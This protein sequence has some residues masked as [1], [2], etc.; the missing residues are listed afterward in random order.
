MR[1]DVTHVQYFIIAWNLPRHILRIKVDFA[2]SREWFVLRNKQIEYRINYH[3]S[4]A[5]FYRPF[6]MHASLA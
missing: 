5:N 1:G 4:H 6:G 3:F 2:L